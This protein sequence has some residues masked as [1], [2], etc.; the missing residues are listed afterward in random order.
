[1]ITLVTWRKRTGT[2]AA[3]DW[4]G[5]CVVR[6]LGS[7]KCLRS[8]PGCPPPA[9]C[10]RTHPAAERPRPLRWPLGGWGAGISPRVAVQ[11]QPLTVAVLAL[12]VHLPPHRPPG[13]QL[14]PGGPWEPQW[15]GGGGSRFLLQSCPAVPHPSWPLSSP[16]TCVFYPW[17]P[18]PHLNTN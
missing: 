13:F 5:L 10:C 15:P 18:F 17:V 3:T 11:G 6:P 7:C 14:P 4:A 2:T 9:L 12:Q 1:M 8:T 16:V